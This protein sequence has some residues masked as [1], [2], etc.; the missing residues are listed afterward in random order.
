LPLSHNNNPPAARQIATT[1][2]A[3]GTPKTRAIKNLSPTKN[4]AP[5]KTANPP[6]LAF[7]AADPARF[8]R[9]YDDEHGEDDDEGQGVAEIRQAG[10][11]SSS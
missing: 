10:S 11:L 9:V 5:D 3:L 8:A 1:G 7:A 2:S 4:R 6:E